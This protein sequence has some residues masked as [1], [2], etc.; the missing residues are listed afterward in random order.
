MAEYITTKTT[1]PGQTDIATKAKVGIGTTGP[2]EPLHV[3][4]E[5]VGVGAIVQGSYNNNANPKLSIRKSNGTITSPTKITSGH[6]AGMIQFQGY[7]SVGNWHTG[8]DI[9]AITTGD[10]GSSQVPMEMVFRTS[11]NSSAGLV[12]AMRIDENG[13]VGIGESAPKEALDVKGGIKVGNSSGSNPGTL[14][15]DNGKLEVYQGNGWKEI[16]VS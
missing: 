4:T 6:V 16:Q 1:D 12:E 2:D 8:A 9:Y 14:R 3:A 7:D 11:P 5:T 15:F 10:I 13:N